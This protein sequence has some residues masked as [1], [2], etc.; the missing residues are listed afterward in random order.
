MSKTISLRVDNLDELRD[1]LHHSGLF[2]M[3]D[4]EVEIACSME[5]PEDDVEKMFAL[6]KSVI[7]VVDTT[8]TPDE[9]VYGYKISLHEVPPPFAKTGFKRHQSP[10]KKFDN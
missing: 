9:D 1:S 10:K 5:N 4:C 8:Y 7:H 6:I 3:S 2:E